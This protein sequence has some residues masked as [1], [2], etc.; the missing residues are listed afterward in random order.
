[1]DSGIPQ[2]P[3]PLTPL[4]WLPPHLADQF[5]TARYICA[6]TVGA[7]MWDVLVSLSE[8]YT[9]FRRKFRL[10]DLVYVLARLATMSFI[11]LALAFDTAKVSNCESLVKSIGAF[12]C[13]HIATN[14]L[15]FLFRIYAIFSGERYILAFFTFLWVA[16][17]ACSITAPFSLHGVHIGTTEYCI[18]DRVKPYGSAGI[19][20]SAVNDT[21]VFIAISL[22]LMS[23]TPAKSTSERFRRFFRGEGMGDLTRAVVHGGQQYYLVT[24]AINIVSTAMILTPSV[25]LAYGNVMAI[26]NAVLQNT[27]AAR[28]FRQLKLGYIASLN[29]QHTSTETGPIQFVSTIG[30]ETLNSSKNGRRRSTNVHFV[31]DST[32]S[33]KEDVEATEL[34]SLHSQGTSG[35]KVR[36]IV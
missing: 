11:L 35:P 12:A 26:P 23:A 4:A 6:V 3:N 29:T 27:M 14:S 21:L 10:P 33:M 13:I 16:A 20:G 30:S 17:V 34:A 7:F 15:L 25:P 36:H 2:L 32:G 22:K 19:V 1:M 24:V 18:F 8:E 5:E 28:V 31:E 9:L